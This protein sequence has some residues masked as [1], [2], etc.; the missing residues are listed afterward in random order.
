MNV[1]QWFLM[2]ERG[3]VT[4]KVLVLLGDLLLQKLTVKGFQPSRPIG[5][6]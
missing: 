5:V 3:R 1:P 4:H 6:T 2:E